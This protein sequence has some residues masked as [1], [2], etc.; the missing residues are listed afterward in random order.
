MMIVAITSAL[1]PA[2]IGFGY[3]WLKL[4]PKIG[5]SPPWP[6]LFIQF[7]KVLG[8]AVLAAAAFKWLLFAVGAPEH[9]VHGF[10]GLA[11]PLI[12]CGYYSRKLFEGL[13][14]AP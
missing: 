12:C 3:G 11:L 5:V 9:V 13:A 7:S 6:W 4:R 14:S 1:L 10:G 2:A 8:V